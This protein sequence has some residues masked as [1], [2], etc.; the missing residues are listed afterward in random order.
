MYQYLI[1]E[2][3][4]VA[5]TILFENNSLVPIEKYPL[6]DLQ[7]DGLRQ[8]LRLGIAADRYQCV[9]AISVVHVLNG[10]R[11]DRTFIQVRRHVVRGRTDQLNATR[12]RLMLGLGTLK[13]REEGVMDV[14]SRALQFFTQ[15]V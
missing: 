5:T 4:E 3:H 12:M 6:L 13:A 11:D 14:N 15:T 1:S 2:G 8:G 7:F 9:G 10:L